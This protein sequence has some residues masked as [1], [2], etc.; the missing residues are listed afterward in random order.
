MGEVRPFKVEVGNDE[1]AYL[2]QRLASARRPLPEPLEDIKPW[3]D[4]TD[5]EYLEVR[6]ARLWGQGEGRTGPD[7][8]SSG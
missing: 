4:G 6:T 3:E 8:R 2:G 7:G 5:R 1:L